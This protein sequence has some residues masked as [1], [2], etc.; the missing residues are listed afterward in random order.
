MVYAGFKSVLVPEGNGQQNPGES[1]TMK[2][3]KHVACSYYYKVVCVD[4]KFSQ[5][6]KS[7]LS[8]NAITTLLIVWLNKVSTSMMWWKTF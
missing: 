4:D 5:P 3:Q 6:F 7:Y 2:Y 8:E 1:Y